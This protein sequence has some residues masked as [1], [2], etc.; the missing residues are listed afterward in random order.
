[1]GAALLTNPDLLCSILTAL[2]KE[3]PPNITVSAKIRLLPSQEDTLKLVER[4]VNTGISAL[5]VHCRTRSMRDKDE[6]LIERLREIVDFV[7]ST[8]KGI[9]VIENGDTKDWAHAKRVREL[10]GAHSVMIARGAE[11]NPSCF[12]LNP[13]KDVET[14]LVPAYLRLVRSL[15]SGQEKTLSHVLPILRVNIW[16]PT[17]VS[18]SSVS[19]SSNHPVRM[20]QKLKLAHSV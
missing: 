18:P 12:S 11:A 10:T 9:A 17:G 14:T 4:I 13:L 15:C 16:T 20:L 19:T 2:R 1:M 6:A 7:E 8:G 5:T 3:L